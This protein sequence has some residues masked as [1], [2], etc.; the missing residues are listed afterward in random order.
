MCIR[1]RAEA[2]ELIALWQG[3]DDALSD[4]FVAEATQNGVMPWEKICL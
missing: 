2:P 3:L 1:D 4:Q